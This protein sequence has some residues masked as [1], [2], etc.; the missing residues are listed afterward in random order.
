MAKNKLSKEDFERKYAEKSGVTVEYLRVHRQVAIP[1]DCE[2]PI[3]SG[4]QMV[5]EDGV[6]IP[7]VRQSF[8][9]G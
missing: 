5:N 3:C 7:S 6:F 8:A 1:C 4:W 2:D 9:K